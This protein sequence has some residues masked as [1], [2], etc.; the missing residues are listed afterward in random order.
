VS[1][2]EMKGGY[3]KGERIGGKSDVNIRNF[4]IRREKKE[5][6][7]QERRQRNLDIRREGSHEF[8]KQVK[9]GD[10]FITHCPPF[11]KI[12]PTV[13]LSSLTSKVRV[14]NVVCKT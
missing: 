2:K 13:S 9:Q 4:N 7:Y 1:A 10:T 14:G 3:L 8:Q 11:P 5:F 12:L 6:Q